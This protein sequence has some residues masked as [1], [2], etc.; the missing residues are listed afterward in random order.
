MDMCVALGVLGS[1]SS[2]SGWPRGSRARVECEW[3][4]DVDSRRER[5]SSTTS[6]AGR[7]LL[8]G[9][10][11]SHISV[12]RGK[13]FSRMRSSKLDVLDD[14]DRAIDCM[15]GVLERGRGFHIAFRLGRCQFRREIVDDEKME[16]HSAVNECSES[17]Q[18]SKIR[19]CSAC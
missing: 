1:I 5:S 11:G 9:G 4:V 14:T 6:R 8:G 19:Q 3:D 17:C 10:P 15:E 13:S 12:W 2:E 16:A 7:G 18:R